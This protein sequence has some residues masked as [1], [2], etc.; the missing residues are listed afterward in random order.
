MV[1]RSLGMV[2]LV[3]AACGDSAGEGDTSGAVSTS[4]GV[5]GS[6]T[7]TG[8]VPTTGEPTTGGTSEGP[9]E[10][11]CCGCLCVDP[12][13]SCGENTCTPEGGG[14]APLGNEAGFVMV[15]EHAIE[16]RTGSEVLALTAPPSRV[17]YAFRPAIE[18][19]ES[20]PLAVF[21]NGGPGLSTAVLFG[22]NTG[23]WT[24]D[25][26]VAGDAVIAENPH[27]WTRFANLLY[28]D[29]PQTGYS[30]DVARANGE[31]PVVPFIPE[32]DAAVLVRVVLDVLAKHP[33]IRD[34]RVILVG[35]SWGGVRASIMG[36][37]LLFAEELRTGPTYR[38]AGLHA[39]IQAHLAAVFPELPADDPAT[40]A[41]QFGHRV[42]IQPVIAMSPEYDLAPRTDYAQI[43]AL[44]GCVEFGDPYQCDEAGGWTLERT[45]AILRAVVRPD[46]LSH[47]L[48]LEVSTIAWLHADARATAYP[49]VPNEGY[50]AEDDAALRALLGE[51][52]DGHHYY[53]HHWLAPPL[54]DAFYAAHPGYGRLFVRTLPFVRTLVT[55]AGKDSLI[56]SPDLPGQIAYHGDLVAS[57]THEPGRIVVQYRPE[58]G[59]RELMHT[60]RFPSYP[61]AGH[62]VTARAPGE[63]LADVEA[64]YAG[65]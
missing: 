50:H 60:I 40:A 8:P 32:H 30:Y 7:G 38:D 23:K 51:L 34:N 13:V 6:S 28:V 29:P 64:W 44:N 49:R 21:F 57:A 5:S 39:R 14:P 35:E 61:A 45:E 18:A 41:R 58:S 12:A 22:T 65:E 48:G 9:A 37:Q 20:R 16:V 63:L 11:V 56:Y 55:H 24:L 53:L 15:E 52:P 36:Q 27:A 2:A 33:Q 17:W 42:L 26:A 3:C 19:P 25:P 62:M 31:Q 1:L 46:A 47:M 54:P 59:L 10:P 43:E 4:E